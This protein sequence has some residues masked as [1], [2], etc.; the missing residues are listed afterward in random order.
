MLSALGAVA[1][2]LTPERIALALVAVA[3]VRL[4][5]AFVPALLHGGIS[6]GLF[7]ERERMATAPQSEPEEEIPDY[8]EA[9]K[10]DFSLEALRAFDGSDSSKPLLVGCKSNIYDMAKG[11]DFYGKG[12]PYNCFAGRDA[13]VAL[14]KMAFNEEYLAADWENYK[15]SQSESDILDDW[16]K[17]FATKYP[18]VGKILK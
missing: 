15:M 13:S 1:A 14:A 6:L 16:E 10:A 4:L 5:L 9:E 3:S 17:K 12:G 11:K 7:R 8:P 2:G 18:L